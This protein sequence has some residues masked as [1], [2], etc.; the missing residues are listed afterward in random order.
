MGT[1]SVLA[2]DKEERHRLIERLKGAGIP[3]HDL[4]YKTFAFAKSF[5]KFELQARRFSN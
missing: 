3:T 1:V 4:L 5:I 2:D